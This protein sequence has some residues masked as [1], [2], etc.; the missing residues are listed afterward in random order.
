MRRKIKAY[1]NY[2]EHENKHIY[3]NFVEE[4]KKPEVGSYYNGEEVLNIE[5]VKLDCE[6]PRP[7]VYD[8]DFYR[9]TTTMNG[10]KED[11]LEFDICVYREVE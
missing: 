3:V 1:V 7:E 8:Y 4:D 2:V 6:Q 9:V 10:E 11:T 5:P